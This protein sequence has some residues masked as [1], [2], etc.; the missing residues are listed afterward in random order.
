[1]AENKIA[2]RPDVVPFM[3][4]GESYENPTWTRMGTGWTSFNENP[5]AQTESTQYINMASE[6]NDTTG[7]SPQY[8]FGCDLMYEDPTIKK[9]YY[10]AKDRKIGSDATVDV[11]IVD[12]FGEAPYTAWRESLAVEVTSIDGTK[13][14]T[15]SGNLNGQGD[16][17]KGKFTPSGES[18]TFTADE[19]ANLST[20]GGQPIP[21]PSSTSKYDT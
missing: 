21:V 4:T 19:K 14:M 12:M 10:I 1:M 15:M 2:M 18:G 16:S 17:I 7:Y 3:N 9:V 11:L 13:K 20:K 5:N 6:N 8:S